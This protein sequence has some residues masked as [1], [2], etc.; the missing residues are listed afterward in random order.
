MCPPPGSLHHVTQN[1]AASFSRPMAVCYPH[2]FQVPLI[3]MYTKTTPSHPVGSEE[4]KKKKKRSSEKERKKKKT[5]IYKKQKKTGCR[6]ASK[7]YTKPKPPEAFSEAPLPPPHYWKPNC[8][9]RS[10]NF[11]VSVSYT[12]RSFLE[13]HDDIWKCRKLR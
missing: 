2:T 4:E 3:S 7:K 9:S 10:P 8:S 11:S 5:K 1:P 13:E 6:D 12:S